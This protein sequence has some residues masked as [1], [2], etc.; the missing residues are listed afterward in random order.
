[1]RGW[2]VGCCIIRFCG[3]TDRTP[4]RY[5][6]LIDGICDLWGALL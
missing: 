1:M 2:G 3:I 6:D 5:L 4:N